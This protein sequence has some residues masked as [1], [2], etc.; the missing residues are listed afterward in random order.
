MLKN[1]IVRSK[2]SK[3]EIIGRGDILPKVDPPHLNIPNQENPID[4]KDHS[5]D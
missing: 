1:M 4:S 3:K 5:S 2:S